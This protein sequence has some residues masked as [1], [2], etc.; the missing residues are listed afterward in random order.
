ML[1]TLTLLSLALSACSTKAGYEGVKEGARNQC[2]TQ[3]PGEIQSCL[4]RLNTQTYEEYEKART[5]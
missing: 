3:P 4:D 5:K 2:R 1:C